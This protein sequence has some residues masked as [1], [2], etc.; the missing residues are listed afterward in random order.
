M[1]AHNFCRMIPSMLGWI[2]L[3]SLYLLFD[4]GKRA[5]LHCQSVNPAVLSLFLEVSNVHSHDQFFGS[6][7]VISI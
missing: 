5:F 3:L 7:V 2:A 1:L 6:Q 4:S